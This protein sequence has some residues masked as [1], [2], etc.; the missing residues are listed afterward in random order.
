M[1]K[2][3]IF[4]A[5]VRP[6]ERMTLRAIRSES[7][8]RKEAVSRFNKR[9]RAWAQHRVRQYT[10]NL[11]VSLTA[12]TQLMDN[13]YIAACVQ[14]AA[15][16]RKHDSRLWR[17]YSDRILQ[18]QDTLEPHDLGYILWGY[19]K[20]GYLDPRLYIGLSA[21]IHDTLPEFN[22]HALMA[23]M[24]CMKRINYQDK[25]LV[26]ATVRTAV[27]TIEKVRP[28][29][30]IK[31]VNG[32]ASLGLSNKDICKRVQE[33][34]IPKLEETFAQGFRD[35]VNP[36]AISFIYK[37]SPVTRYLLERFRRI[38]IT[39]RPHHMMHAYESAIAVR[40]LYPQ[41]WQ[42]L[43]LEVKAF[44]VR[45]SQRHIKSKEK[46]PS[47]V[48]WEISGVLASE[49][50]FNHRNTFRW[51]PFSVD[52]GLDQVD[53]DERRDCIMV[54]TPTSYFFNTNQYR[55]GRQLRHRLLSEL[56]W[57]VRR[58]RWEDWVQL[59]AEEKKPFLENM[60]CEEPSDH[61]FDRHPVD[62]S[63]LRHL[64]KDFNTR[65]AARQAEREVR[66]LDLD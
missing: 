34:T 39:A 10:L 49:M 38:H 62:M 48:Q 6:R 21:R 22:S 57:K 52:V 54:D 4:S 41:I 31:I 64:Y 55:P 66:E 1:P 61:L 12:D 44:Y 32:A 36:L 40:L 27:E 24:W 33:V 8:M 35:A 65:Y 45:M 56:G 13:K 15:R 5:L 14:K 20:S 17:G 25:E 58:V 50:E 3:G 9:W 63:E 30:F 47:N 23:L 46:T 60:L 43:P 7:R 26:A 29:D 51:G 18:I 42:E 19:G 37:D 11:P 59:Q 16:L 2:G 28:S 53:D